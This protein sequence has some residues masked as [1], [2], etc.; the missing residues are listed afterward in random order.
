MARITSPH[1][2]FGFQMGTDRKMAR[3]DKIVDYF[4][5]LDAASPR[6]KVVELGKSTEDNPFLLAVIS[7]PE[8]LDN[9]E[10]LRQINL[11]LAD[12]RGLAEKEV[13]GLV[14]EGKAV[15]CQSMSLHASEIGGTQMTPELA[16]ELLTRDDEETLRILDNVVFLMVPCFNPD[17]Q[18]MVTDWYNKW[19][20]TEY[21]GCPL[22]WLYQKY[23]GHDNNRDA[24]AL[25][26]PEAQHMAGVLFRD[27]KPQAYQDH[28]HMMTDSARYSIAPYCNPIHPYGDP[29]IWR[30][31]A[32]YGAHMAYKLE[33]AGKKGIINAAI[34]PGWGHL[35]FH[36]I[37]IYHNIAGML[38]E[39]ASAKLATP[40]YV[41]PS[42]LTGTGMFSPKTFPKYEAL[43]NFPNPWEGGWWHLRDIVEQKKISAW[44]LLDLA[45]RHKETVLWNAYHKAT[46]QA[47]RGAADKV[48]AYC[49]RPDQHD[50]LTVRKLVQKLLAQ[51]IE[52]REAAEAFDCDG[53]CFPAGTWL[54]PLAQPKMGLIKTLLGRTAYVDNY[55]SRRPDGSPMVFDT[56]TDTIAE[57]MGVE[58]VPV[59]GLPQVE[60]GAASVALTCGPETGCRCV[61]AAVASG[62]AGWLLDCRQNDAYRVVNRLL[63]AGVAVSRLS[64]GTCVG[65]ACYDPGAFW[66]EAG[67]GAAEILNAAAV[68][69]GVCAQA[70]PSAPKASMV[71][72]S[73]KRV[74]MYQRYY[75][76]NMDEGW[77]RFVFDSFEFPYQTI[78]DADVKG[79]DLNERFDVIVLPADHKE[80][81]TDITKADRKDPRVQMFLQFYGV[82]APPEYRSGFGEQGVAALREFVAKGG[83]LVTM[84]LASG[85]AI[86]ALGLAVRDVTANLDGNKYYSKGNTVRVKSDPADPLAWGMPEEFLALSWDSPVFD[87]TERFH[88]DQYR[89]VAH[90]PDGGILE[91]GW[92]VGEEVIAGKPAMVVA[93]HGQ[94]E[95]VLIGIRPQHRGQMHGTFKLLFNCLF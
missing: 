68:G 71:A 12:P 75:G 45:A 11:K 18:I 25:N 56:A 62:A 39:S 55:F 19:L 15:I 29:L 81:M 91:S 1:E 49:I 42:Q 46:R 69:L 93:Q 50:P 67:E 22:P 38:T 80:I 78:M 72:V 28:H 24:Y 57:F 66:V 9:L 92:L 35:G 2:F 76:G 73:A 89:V 54:V 77:T 10:H 36:W 43:T 20:G 3:W 26:M 86:D 79:G 74:G 37:T 70:A 5:Q 33:E 59:G 53:R 16:H 6:I 4:W 88:P 23:T 31:H 34:F 47:E 51:G 40:L 30:E 60:A 95:A 61:A 85:L 65:P 27:W 64:E 13:A 87:I 41:H 90:Y 21:E 44:A 83:R 94:G 84:G 32:W 8:N 48:K 58:A 52:V 63:A 7:A 17:G 82:G 14:K